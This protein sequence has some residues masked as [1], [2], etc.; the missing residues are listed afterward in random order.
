[1]A[2]PSSLHVHAVLLTLKC[3]Q[4][5]LYHG[6]LNP[7]Q[8]ISTGSLTCRVVREAGACRLHLLL[9]LLQAPGRGCGCVPSEQLC[10]KV[11]PG[12]D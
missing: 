6:G 8:V 1:M 2:S 11:L 4:L 9:L 7:K 5:L 12:S 10:N 3:T